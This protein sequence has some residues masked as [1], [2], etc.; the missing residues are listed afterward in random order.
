MPDIRSIIRR[1]NVYN[2][3]TGWPDGYYMGDVQRLQAGENLAAHEL[4]YR[5]NDGKQWKTDADA[6]ATTVG[7]L[8]LALEVIGADD[9]GFFLSIGHVKNTG[10]AFTAGDSLY[11]SATSGAITATA[12][13]GS[14]QFLRKVGG[15]VT[16]NVIFFNPDGTVVEIS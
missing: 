14:G 7:V 3:I 2:D 15:A 10:W 9:Y 11:V 5:K 4:T 8:Y 6:E 12:L 13:S 16:S 1:W